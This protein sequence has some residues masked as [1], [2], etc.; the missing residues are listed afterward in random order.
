MHCDLSVMPINGY[1]VED[2]AHHLFSQKKNDDI[3][4]IES[5]LKDR[6]NM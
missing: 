1:E 5:N 6:H 4:E 2:P 3:I